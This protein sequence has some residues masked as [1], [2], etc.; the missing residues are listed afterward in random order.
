MEKSLNICL[1]LQR[2]FVRFGHALAINIKNKNENTKFS[3]YTHLKGSYDFIKNQTEIN[4][5][6]IILDEEVH[7]KYKNE[8]IDFNFL[9]KIENKYG[10]PNIWP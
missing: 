2:S 3:A 6:Q 9:K 8:K 5:S 4:Y 10:I 1:F 7:E